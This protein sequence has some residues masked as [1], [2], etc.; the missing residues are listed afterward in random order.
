MRGEVSDAEA[1]LK[2]A[3]RDTSIFERMP[4]LVVYPQDTADVQ[5][6]VK[7][8]RSAVSAGAMVSVTARA[9]GTDMSGG[10]L[11]TSVVIS[12]TK[13]MHKIVEVAACRTPKEGGYAVTEPGVYYRDF[14]KATLAQGFILPSYPASRELCAM[15]GIVANNSGGERTLE[16]GKTEKY[17]EELEVV[18]SDGSLATFKALTP[19]ELEAKKSQKDF[20]GEIYR[21][22][23]ALLTKNAALIEEH[24][25]KVSK[26]SAGYALWS[27]R[28]RYS[29]ACLA[30]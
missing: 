21:K 8:V 14:E 7:E 2:T 3:S 6:I 19:D 4:E 10:P 9:A 16:Y 12:F 13:N 25:P 24:R 30:T 23:D 17:V 22:M 15:G 1:D 29:D 27:V 5:A 11:T 18:L 28:D 26:N 20:E